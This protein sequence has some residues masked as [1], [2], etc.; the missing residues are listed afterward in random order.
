MIEEQKPYLSLD[1]ALAKFVAIRDKAGNGSMPFLVNNISF[2]FFTRARLLLGRATKASIWKEAQRGGVP[3][4][5]VANNAPTAPLLTLD[6]AIAKLEGF[7]KELGSGDI[8]FLA[9]GAGQNTLELADVWQTAVGV[10][11][12]YQGVSRGGRP[13]AA[14]MRTAPEKQNA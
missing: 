7:R 10:S 14:V 11:N 4:V 1:E 12:M 5:V 6:E 13:A 8:P 3:V 2:S 9:R